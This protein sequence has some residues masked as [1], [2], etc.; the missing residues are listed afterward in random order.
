MYKEI[1]VDIYKVLDFLSICL[2]FGV[3]FRGF[4]LFLILLLS[5]YLANYAFRCTFECNTY[6]LGITLEEV[7]KLIYISGH[8]RII[9]DPLPFFSRP[10]TYRPT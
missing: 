2:F 8:A 4:L 6:L 10:A 9:L 1:L 7:L 5:H 3:Y